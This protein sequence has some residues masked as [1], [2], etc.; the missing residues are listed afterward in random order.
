MRRLFPDREGPV[1]PR[2]CR[3]AGPSRWWCRTDRRRRPS[4]RSKCRP[5]ISTRSRVVLYRRL[6]RLL[7]PTLQDRRLSWWLRL[8]PTRAACPIVRVRLYPVRHPRVRRLSLRLV[9]KEPSEVFPFKDGLP[10]SSPSSCNL[11][12]APR[13]KSRSFKRPYSRQQRHLIAAA[14]HR[15]RRSL[16]VRRRDRWDR[17]RR[18]LRRRHRRLT[19]R[20]A[21][22]PAAARR[23][24]LPRTHRWRRPVPCL[25]PAVRRPFPAVRR[26]PASKQ[27][28]PPIRPVMLPPCRRW[29][30]RDSTERWRPTARRSRQR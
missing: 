29:Q 7:L 28:P 23:P 20:R 5:S 22:R 8:R 2:P 9:R 6:P 13:F 18:C 25:S 10:G 11:S 17:R 24:V 16:C 14:R 12:K 26:P 30:R 15:R 27:C 1:R 3:R 4:S 19:R 21:T